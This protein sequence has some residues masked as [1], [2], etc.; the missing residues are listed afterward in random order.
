MATGEVSVW[1]E[2]SGRLVLGSSLSVC[3]GGVCV[4]GWREG[5]GWVVG[6]CLPLLLGGMVW[7]AV[8]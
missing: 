6:L 2:W 1:V 3:L 5:F 4:S 7:M 8:C